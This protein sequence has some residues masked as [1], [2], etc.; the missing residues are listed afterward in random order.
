MSKSIE[1]LIDELIDDSAYQNGI[2]WV[3]DYRT[4]MKQTIARML[5]YMAHDS[6]NDI[7]PRIVTKDL[8]K[9]GKIYDV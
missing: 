4:E 8:Y 7:Q 5:V 3:G 6:R 1:S 9:E 2:H